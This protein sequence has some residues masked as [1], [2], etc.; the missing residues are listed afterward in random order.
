MNEYFSATEE[1]LYKLFTY[2][3]DDRR[4]FNVF[5]RILHLNEKLLSIR[6][7]VDKSGFESYILSIEI[8]ANNATNPTVENRLVVTTNS[9]QSVFDYLYYLMDKKFPLECLTSEYFHKFY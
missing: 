8:V 9:F 5:Y 4:L 6:L 2:T 1:A 3:T 7:D